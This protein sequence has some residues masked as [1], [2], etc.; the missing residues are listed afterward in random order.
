MDEEETV[1][2]TTDEVTREDELG[3]IFD[4]A[5]AEETTEVA[6]PVEETPS[7]ERPRGP[8]GKFVAKEQEGAKPAETTEIP[9]TGAEP[10]PEAVSQ[11]LDAP[12]SWTAAAKV[13]WPNLDPVLQEEFLRREADWQRT[14]GERANKLKGYEPIEAAIEPVRQ[15]LELNGVEP[16]QYV[17]QLVAADQFLRT[18]PTAGFNWLAQQYGFDLSQAL[19][20]QPEVDPT[21]QPFVQ[22]INALEAALN[23]QVV[24]QQTAESK[25]IDDELSAFSAEHPHFEEVRADMGALIQSGAAADLK[26]AY[27]KA[28]WAN[29]STR[30]ALLAEQSTEAAAKQKEEAGKKAAD[31]KRISQTNLSSAGTAGGKTPPQFANREEE[32]GSIYDQVQGA[33]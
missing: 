28:V 12:A 11:S 17:R 20:G 27:D 24:A 23:Q 33:A 14:D 16:A 21:M 4:A 3:A 2:E 26:S 32:L 31:A 18:D 22:K 10:E 13:Q 7:D 30:T 1:E 6:E 5:N 15:H 19:E 25:R 9:A 29:P 8:D